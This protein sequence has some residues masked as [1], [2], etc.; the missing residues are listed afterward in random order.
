MAKD[1]TKEDTGG[2]RLA[3]KGKQGVKG[4]NYNLSPKKQGNRKEKY[5]QERGGRRKEGKGQGAR[6]EITRY[7]EMVASKMR[8]ALKKRGRETVRESNSRNNN[9]TMNL[10][11]ELVYRGT[12]GVFDPQRKVDDY[13]RHFLFSR[14]T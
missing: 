4:V 8:A 9:V 2:W 5:S 11:L 12:K 7:P 1:G 6:G 10:T 3:K 14:C 13:N